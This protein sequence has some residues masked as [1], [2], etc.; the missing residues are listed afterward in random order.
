LGWASGAAGRISPQR[1]GHL[2]RTPRDRWRPGVV[3]FDSHDAATIAAQGPRA[4]TRDV[5]QH[6]V[7]S[8]NT[9][10]DHLKSIFTKTTTRNR[11]TLVARAIGT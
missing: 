9:V 3:V 10:Q 1:L 11:R 7:V 2:H 4:N 8:E 6:L 5:A